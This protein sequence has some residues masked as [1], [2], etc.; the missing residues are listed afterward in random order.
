MTELKK[1]L[2][3]SVDERIHLVQTIWDS[4]AVDTE[5]SEIS[6]E[7]KKILNDRMEAHKINP[8]DIVSSARYFRSNC[9]V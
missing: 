8:N 2:K 7:H 3:L 1:I 4:I 5:V 9:L 6:K